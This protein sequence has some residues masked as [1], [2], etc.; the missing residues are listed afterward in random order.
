MRGPVI[1]QTA[2]LSAV[3]T[4][5]LVPKAH[6]IRRIKPIVDAI[7][8]D[9]EPTFRRMYS[10]IG[11]PSIPPEHLLKSTV[12]MAMYS[13]R[14]ERQFCERLQY[15]ML[16]RW[17]LDMGIEDSVFVPTTFTK[18]RERLLTHEVADKFF[19]ASVEQARLR[20]YV[21]DEHFT[22]DGS[23][24]EAWAS[25]KSF[26]P[27]AE[28]GQ[29]SAD[30]GGG[31]GRDPEVDFHGE[32]RSNATHQSTTDPEALLMRKSNAHAA[33]LQYSAHVLMENRSGL[34]VETELTQATG[35]AERDTAIELLK[36]LPGAGRQRRPLGVDKG[37]DTRDF[38]KGCR[39][40]KVTPHVAQNVSGRRSAIDDRTTRHAG[41]AVSQR[42]RKRV[43][44]I[45]GW[46]KTVGGCRK[47]R[48][49][50]RKRNRIWTMFSG[51]T[52][53]LTR[54][55]NLDRDAALRAA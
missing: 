52:F 38:V 40:L 48:F 46:K 14:S 13:V 7:L 15:D 23:L 6:P 16:F 42:I 45:F 2:M 10:V 11:R 54:I 4:E 47:L 24:L 37:Y 29:G 28:G 27:R 35:Y 1:H 20:G 49:V 18:N 36:R 5:D 17:F 3:T 43:E 55:A 30:S 44:E 31:A 51:A 9:L 32:K 21:S 50:G 25:V 12:L 53:N 39:E 26:K 41:Y 33:K 8:V 19:K 34:I 22:A